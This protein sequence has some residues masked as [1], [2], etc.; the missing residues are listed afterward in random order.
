MKYLKQVVLPEGARTAEHGSTGQLIATKSRCLQHINTS[1]C[2]IYT[3]DTLIVIKGTGEEVQQPE[4]LK[5][6]GQ[7]SDE[8]L[9]VNREQLEQ[10]MERLG[11]I[12]TLESS[13]LDA[14]DKLAKIQVHCI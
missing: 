6:Q 1:V 14:R 13:T 10:E 11:N 2:C 9:R 4:Q 5:E 12:F 3:Y 8:V 7:Q